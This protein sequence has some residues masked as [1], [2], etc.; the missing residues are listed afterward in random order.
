MAQSVLKLLRPPYGNHVSWPRQPHDLGQLRDC[1][2]IENNANLS[3]AVERMESGPPRNA[4]RVGFTRELEP[5][6]AALL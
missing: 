3:T 5:A 6:R 1:L 2:G 4:P